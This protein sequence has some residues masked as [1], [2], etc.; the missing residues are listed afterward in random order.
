MLKIKQN[1][2]TWGAKCNV[3]FQIIFPKRSAFFDSHKKGIIVKL[4]LV[5]AK[6]T[7]FSIFK[8]DRKPAFYQD[9][10]VS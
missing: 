1:Q 8:G 2:R 7:S 4:I 9:S 6:V 10:V 3:I 5:L